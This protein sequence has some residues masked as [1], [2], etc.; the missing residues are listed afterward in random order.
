MNE[1]NAKSLRIIADFEQSI[2]FL[3]DG[4]EKLRNDALKYVVDKFAEID[5]D[6]IAFSHAMSTEL[7]SDIFELSSK[8][9]HIE[10][11]NGRHDI[12]KDGRFVLNTMSWNLWFE[13]DAEGGR[14][15][16]RNDYTNSQSGRAIIT[17][18]IKNWDDIVTQ[19]IIDLQEKML[20]YDDHVS[21]DYDIAKAHL[22][23]LKNEEV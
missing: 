8:E 23:E 7:A 15:I 16:T 19:M 10:M 4:T 5:C 6:I 2:N 9:Y 20:K 11:S 13:S 22:A 18:L 14:I 12:T 1:L 3:K 21:R 17:C